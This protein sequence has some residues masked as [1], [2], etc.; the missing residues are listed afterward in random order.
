[1]KSGQFRE[2]TYYADVH[3]LWPEGESRLTTDKVRDYIKLWCTV[4]VTPS[5]DSWGELLAG[6]MDDRS[7]YVIVLYE[8][9]TA[10][11]MCISTLVHEVFHCADQ[12]LTSR[13][14]FQI[15]GTDN[16]PYAY[17]IDSLF[18]RC[19]EIINQKQK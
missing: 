5:E 18:R 15:P 4:D 3:I 19:L 12:I 9:W 13:G 16:E 8:P 2:E 6:W 10:T 17:L 1:M 14:V 7:A 11:P